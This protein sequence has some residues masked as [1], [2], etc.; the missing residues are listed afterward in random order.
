MT[1]PK[2]NRKICRLHWFFRRQTGHTLSSF[3]GHA[4][5]AAGEEKFHK[6]DATLSL[7]SRFRTGCVPTNRRART[8]SARDLQRRQGLPATPIA[9]FVNE[10]SRVRNARLVSPKPDVVPELD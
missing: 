2:E 10:Q 3:G 7:E 4:T 9:W 1:E 6:P 5:A 8:A